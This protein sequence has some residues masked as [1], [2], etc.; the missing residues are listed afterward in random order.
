ME[1][2]AIFNVTVTG[3]ES[4]QPFNGQFKVKTLLS[5]RD[6]L[7]ADEIRRELIGGKPE[8]ASASVIADALVLSQLAVRIIESPAWWQNSQGGLDLADANVIGEVFRLTMDE[9]DKRAAALKKES[10]E[11]LKKLSQA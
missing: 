9:A 2:T 1:T 4:G 8:G 7:R 5:R 11:A 10:E 3:E 6:R